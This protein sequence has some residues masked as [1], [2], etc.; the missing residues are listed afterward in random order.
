MTRTSTAIQYATY[1]TAALVL[2]TF[3]HVGPKAWVGARV[4]AE[5]ALEHTLQGEKQ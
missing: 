3:L 5:T 4:I 1:A 2:A